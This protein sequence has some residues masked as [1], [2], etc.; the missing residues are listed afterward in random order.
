MGAEPGSF[1]VAVEASGTSVTVAITGELDLSTAAQLENVL[2]PLTD[3]SR[4][5]PVQQLVL[6]ATNLA[7]ADVSGLAPLIRCAQ[8]LGA[9]G[10]SVRLQH[11]PRPVRR[12]IELL[13]LAELLGLSPRGVAGA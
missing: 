11:A 4:R 8:A 2:G 3:P 13:D 1:D 12:V 6:D 10:A 5:P 7:F 9:R